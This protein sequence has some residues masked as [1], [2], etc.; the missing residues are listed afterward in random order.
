MTII[1]RIQ[2]LLD[3]AMRGV[4]TSTNTF[5]VGSLTIGSTNLTETVL[6]RFIALQNGTDV[7]TS[8]HTHDTVYTRTSTLI[9]TAGSANIGDGNTYTN[10]TPT[11]ATVKGALSG[12]DT[13]LSASTSAN[14]SLSNLT[15]P[16]SINQDLIPS[17]NLTRT[18]GSV[19][20]VWSAMWVKELLYPSQLDFR[21]DTGLL[22]I[23][24]GATVVDFSNSRLQDASNGI[25]IDW[26]NRLLEDAGGNVSVD[27]QNRALKDS[28][29]AIQL[30]WSASG[31][32][33]NQ[34]TASTV[35]Y[36]SSGKVLT[37]SA[38]TPTE[39]GYVSGVTSSIQTQF[40]G[41]LSLTGGTM[42]GAINMGSNQ[43]NNLADPTSAQDAATKHYVDNLAQGLSWKNV[44]RSATTTT[45]PAYNYV[46]GVITATSNGA[47]T[48][49]D[50]VT[51]S[52]NDRLLVKN[53]TGANQPF[54]GVYVVTATGDGSNP[55]VLT[56]AI[57]VSTAAELTWATVQVGADASTQAGYI[58]RESDDVV[59]LGTDNVAFTNVTQGTALVFTNGL[60]QSG[61]TVSASVDGSTIDLNGSSQ[62][63]VKAAGIGTTQLA[64]AS[65]TAAK[66]ATVTDGITL[67][68]SGA[69]ST[70]EIK[71]GGVGTTQLA[72]ASVT[73]AKLA[74]GAVTAT[75]LGSVTDGITLD[76][77]GAGSTIEIKSAGVGTTQLAAASVTTAKLGT[78]TDGVTLDQSGAGS[79]LEVK[80]GGIGTTQLASAAVTPAKLGSVTDGVTLDQSGSG[81]TIEIKTGGVGTSQLA[82]QAVTAAKI[83]TSAV[84]GVTIT[85]GNGSALT[86]V[87][88]PAIVTSVIVGA[89]F[90]ANTTYAVRWGQ[91]ANSETAGRVYA[92]DNNAATTDNFHVIGLIQTGASSLSAGNTATMYRMG[93]LALASNDSA[94]A[95][96]GGPIY[97]GS[98][99]AFTLTPPSAASTASVIV[100]Y[101]ET[102]AIIDVVPAKIM[103]V[104]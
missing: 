68:Q 25:S 64:S 78:I 94:F 26:A 55:F 19:S 70:L 66:L 101:A 46:S 42:S 10:F 99:G 48:A 104:N 65:V 27:Y 30:S 62:L 98:S 52:V 87:Q 58:F 9:S 83:A 12:I 23:G 95:N 63:E 88:V 49:Q 28:A 71:S 67:D 100:G 89:S 51:L 47:L 85:G 82:S 41:K 96:A 72:A 3:G 16:T 103:G 4:D 13:A 84:D 20:D 56:R 60:S 93:Q 50:G 22:T 40:S 45:L 37:S 34:L 33:F 15:S 53:E 102:T 79:T 90:S 76:Q 2:A 77:S 18:M 43:I 17:G 38:V 91:T 1:T 31:V 44:V 59:T 92:A 8:Y 73:T 80:S 81:A 75:I 29:A 36:L 32:E 14:K 61:N 39:L 97:L 86:A 69:G 6:G 57:D 21:L 11:S 7:D 5:V 54:N 24:T 74:T 35:P